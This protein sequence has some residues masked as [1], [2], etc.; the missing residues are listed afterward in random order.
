MKTPKGPCPPIDSTETISGYTPI[1]QFTNEDSWGSIFVEAG[2]H[3]HELFFLNRAEG[4]LPDAYQFPNGN[5]RFFSYRTEFAA[6]LSLLDNASMAWIITKGGVVRFQTNPKN[7]LMTKSK[8]T[9]SNLTP[10]R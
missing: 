9:A 6:V 7:K 5:I 4:A 2:S 10:G 1:L 3:V 8:R